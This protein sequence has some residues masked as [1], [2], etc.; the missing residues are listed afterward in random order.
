MLIVTNI[1]MKM[2]NILTYNLTQNK[3]NAIELCEGIS[4]DNYAKKHH[5]K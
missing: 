3:C 1:C 5:V 4:D 2:D